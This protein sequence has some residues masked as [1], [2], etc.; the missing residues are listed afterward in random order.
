MLGIHV[1]ALLAEQPVKCAGT[2][3]AE[4]LEHLVMDACG[5]KWV[6]KQEDWQYDC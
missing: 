3:L 4:L 1:G 6:Q 2:S 5:D